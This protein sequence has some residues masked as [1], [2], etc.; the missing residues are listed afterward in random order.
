MRYAVTAFWR[1]LNLQEQSFLGY[2][3]ALNRLDGVDYVDPRPE[4]TVNE[5]LREQICD[6]QQF[7]VCDLWI[8]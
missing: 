4:V 1:Q 7:V 3:L 6:F 5:R 2:M 8:L